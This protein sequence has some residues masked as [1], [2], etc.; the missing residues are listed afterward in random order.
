MYNRHKYTGSINYISGLKVADI[1]L[2]L[3]ILPIG[4]SSALHNNFVSLNKFN[5]S[6]ATFRWSL[7]S[8]CSHMSLQ[9]I[10]GKI[11]LCMFWHIS[12]LITTLGK[13]CPTLLA[14]KRS[15]SPGCV[16][17]CV[18]KLLPCSHSAPHSLQLNGISSHILLCALYS[19]D[20]HGADF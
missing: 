6:T 11:L 19:C 8:M 18:F 10:T 1:L 15:I 13:Y 4:G 7:S 2:K 20:F 12:L 14:N 5:K 16:A 17:I 9:I 3:W